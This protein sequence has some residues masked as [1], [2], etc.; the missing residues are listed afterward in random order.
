MMNNLT[1]AQMACLLF[2]EKNG[3]VHLWPGGLGMARKV[4]DG[5]TERGL[6]E[7]VTIRV[8]GQPLEMRSHR[9]TDSGRAILAEIQS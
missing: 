2:V 4:R 9:L 1:K 8:R 7:T 3:T 6:L 5:L